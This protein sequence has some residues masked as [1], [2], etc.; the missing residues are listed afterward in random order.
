MHR[1]GLVCTKNVQ[2][3][4]ATIT[5]Q[6]YA[7]IE[8]GDKMVK[9]YDA[10]DREAERETTNRYW[11]LPP[12]YVENETL[13]RSAVLEIATLLNETLPNTTYVAEWRPIGPRLV[14]R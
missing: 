8:L 4:T 5:I 7:G 1:I 6:N 14:C 13:W 11:W 12:A 10:L 3:T 2:K 9:S